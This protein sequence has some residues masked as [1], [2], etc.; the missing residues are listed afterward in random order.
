VTPELFHRIAEEGS[1]RVRRRMVELG[2]VERIRIRNVAYENVRE[3]LLRL[4]GDDGTPALW[5]GVALYRGTDA[6][7]AELERLAGE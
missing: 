2:L 1:A 7:L 3:D 5:D 6:V 4:G